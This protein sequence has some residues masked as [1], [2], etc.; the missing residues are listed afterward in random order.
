MLYRDK[1]N[2]LA[3]NGELIQS[4][5]FAIVCV[6]I[7]LVFPLAG[8]L[9]SITALV[10]FLLVAPVLY[11]KFILKKNL[12]SI[13]IS[14]VDR[15][16]GLIWG[17]MMLVLSLLM[18]FVL[19]KTPYADIFI[20]PTGIDVDFKLFLLYEL[21]LANIVL[22]VLEFFFHGF[23]LSTLV[24]KFKGWSVLIAGLLFFAFLLSSNNVRWAVIAFTGGL[25]A[26]KT[27]SFVFAYLMGL[28]FMIFFD[29]Y[30]IFIS[31]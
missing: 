19:S 6:L 7:F 12:D 3:E 8:A 18:A 4:I 16:N 20:L 28:I 2:F 27:K 13:G 31:K 9:Q 15:K 21:V 26:Y 24:P 25:V 11:V 1:R 23:I 17:F 10:V 5:V 14:F 30:L 22:F 29:T